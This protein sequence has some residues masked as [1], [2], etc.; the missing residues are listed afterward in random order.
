MNNSNGGKLEFLPVTIYSPGATL[1]AVLRLGIFAGIEESID[2]PGKTFDS[3]AGVMLGIFT[4]LANFTTSI[5]NN[6]DGD[7]DCD[8]RIDETYQ[9]ALGATAGASVA[10][11]PYTWSNEPETQT[12]IFFTTLADICA[13]R[14][15][16]STT[17]ASV[18]TFTKRQDQ[19]LT[20]TTTTTEVV[21]TAVGC[22]SAGLINCP[23]SLQTVNEITSTKTLTTSVAVGSD[24]DWDQ[25]STTQGPISAIPFGRNVKDLG[26]PT[27]GPPKSYVPPPPPTASATGSAGTGAN[28]TGSG[29]GS[30][31]G[32]SETDK[33]IIGVSVGVGVPAVALLLLGIIMCLRRRRNKPIA[34]SVGRPGQSP[35]A[36]N[37]D[38]QMSKPML[39]AYVQPLRD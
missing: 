10:V 20:P 14:G 33:I 37:T 27:T 28:G 9:F 30:G 32:L 35:V 26:T 31:S 11:G 38:L 7:G 23:A 19:S 36:S 15:E 6:D 4:N 25:T 17:T 21:Y 34:V 2:L 39:R 24:V 18:S 3:S 12:P 1:T 13:A 5:A 29:S 16:A 22:E 8:I